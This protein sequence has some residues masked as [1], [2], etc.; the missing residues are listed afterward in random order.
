[1][2]KATLHCYCREGFFDGLKDARVPIASNAG[3]L[4]TQQFEVRQILFYFFINLAGG[5]PVE[6]RVFDVIVPVHNK[7]DITG[8][9]RAIN[10]QMDLFPFSDLVCWR[11]FQV[12]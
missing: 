5:Y 11:F 10:E 9:V 12:L 6:L 7:A 4:D 2:E 1:M 3:Q 8:Q